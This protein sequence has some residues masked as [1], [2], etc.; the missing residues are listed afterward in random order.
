MLSQHFNISICTVVTV[1]GVCYCNTKN[2]TLNHPIYPI[3]PISRLQVLSK[4]FDST[5]GGRNFDW[6]LV[7]H[8][9]KEF[10][11]KYHVDSLSSPRQ[12]LRL[13][14]E[15]EKL[16]KNM[17]ANT[18]SIPINIDCFAEDKDVMGHMKR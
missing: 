5:L 7:D 16:K 15:C 8:F 1:S 6:R 14:N 2:R 17:S 10:N 18:T 3:R 12:K 9:A 11:T 4:A 13:A